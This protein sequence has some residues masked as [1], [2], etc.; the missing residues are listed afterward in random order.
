MQASPYLARP[1]TQTSRITR[2]A[3]RTDA[4]QGD[5]IINMGDLLPPS[6]TQAAG[7][8]KQDTLFGPSIGLVNPGPDWADQKLEQTE[9]GQLQ[10]SLTPELVKTWVE[11]S[12]QVRPY[13]SPRYPRLPYD[14]SP[15]LPSPQRHF[16]RLSTLNDLL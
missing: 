2:A 3:S 12:K 16:R 10:D 6:S 8:K 7:R 13:T 4:Q 5:A 1:E 15:R 14:V 11:K 9:K